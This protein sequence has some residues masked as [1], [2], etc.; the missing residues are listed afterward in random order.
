MYRCFLLIFVAALFHFQAVAQSITLQECYDAARNNSPHLKKISNLHEINDLSI[1][2]L[3]QGQLPQVLLNGQYSY[4]SDVIAF[5]DLPGINFPEIP[6]NQYRLSLDVN[7]NLFN[8]RR[9]RKSILV[10]EE[11]RN[12]QQQ[13]VEVQLSKVKR[14]V[15]ELFFSVLFLQEKVKTYDII[16]TDLQTQLATI[17]SLVRNGVLRGADEKSLIIEIKKITQEKLAINYQRLAAIEMLSEKTGL[18]LD[19]SVS[20]ETPGYNVSGDTSINRVEKKLFQFSRDAIE[21]QKQLSNLGR[22]PQLAAQ[23]SF[24]MGNPNPMN[25]FETGLS[26]FYWV[27]LK[28]SWHIWDW[29]NSSRNKE[30]LSL[31]Q[32]NLVEEENNFDLAIRTQLAGANLDLQK[33]REL[34]MGDQEILNLQSEITKEAFSRYRQ[35]I[36]T[37]SEYSIE[38]NKEIQIR[39][40][41][42]MREI[43]I[44]KAVVNI[45]SITGNM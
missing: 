6:N 10:E 9:V 38:L 40:K 35:G 44:S 26:T 11:M 25:F 21:T 39:I 45:L 24:G 33:L 30:I 13:E 31:K 42:A 28:L 7:Q 20:L 14:T 41:L 23:A 37:S 4:Q 22:Y 2:S 29:N 19:S 43:E 8:G 16:L 15:N 5:P 17:K 27:G 36:I 1:K 32:M 12:V 34:R 3:G 18:A